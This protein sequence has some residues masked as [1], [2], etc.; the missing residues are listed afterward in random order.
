MIRLLGRSRPK[1]PAALPVLGLGILGAL[2]ILGE[3]ARRQITRSSRSEL[4]DEPAKWGLS[5]AEE[6]TFRARDGVRIH[7]WLFAP[8]R[9][10]PTVIL[11]HGHGS[12]KHMMLPV[13][14]FLYPHYN[15]LLI[16]SRGHGESDGDRTTVGYEERLDVHA[17][18]DEVQRRGLGP[19][20]L[21]GISMGAAIAVL[22]A[23][24]DPRIAAVVADS[25]FARLRWAVAEAARRHGYP[26]A[27]ASLAALAGC[28]AMAIRLGYRMTAF[29]PIEV[30][31]RI[32]PRPLLLMHGAEDDVINVSHARALFARAGEPKELWILDELAHCRG[33]E[34]AC[35]AYQAR[36]LSFFERTLRMS[37]SHTAELA[38]IAPQ[39][40]AARHDLNSAR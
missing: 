32:A 20:G 33:L 27:V 39:T 31:D 5:P 4:R 19:V 22:A 10:V 40:T 21:L 25:P 37:S 28:G 8:R 18:I 3:Y 9:P 16:D 34:S 14:H 11:C 24:E 36:I 1:V 12:N 38:G 6:L 13:A 2:A 35:D 26:S 23:A 29:D 30:I 17:A 7:A 15:V